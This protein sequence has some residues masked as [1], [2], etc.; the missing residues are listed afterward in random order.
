VR[1]VAFRRRLYAGGAAAVRDA[2]DPMIEAA[3]L[4][5]PEAR[6]LRKGNE[7]QEEVK[8]Q[9][10]A[11]IGRA[12]FALLGESTYPDATF[13]LRLSYGTVA[14]YVEN[15]DTVPAI[16]TMEGLYAR[17]AAHHDREPFDLPP[18]WVGREAALQP[19]TPLN[20]VTTCDIIGGNSGSPTVN[21]AGEFVGI[22]FD[23]NIHSLA[24]DFGY[25]DPLSRAL[26]VHSAGIIAA[27]RQ[28]YGA[29][30][31]ADELVNGHRP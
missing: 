20:F 14:G 6:A 26:S 31:L 27:I 28:V 25:D 12:R 2:R 8:Q 29:N 5:D 18:R 21:R 1:D 30:A 19:D 9:A 16:T 15:G 7:A 17:S 3:R 4:L 10:Q 13:T 22:I 24:A 11:V 23:G